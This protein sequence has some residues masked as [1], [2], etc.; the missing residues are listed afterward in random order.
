MG[1]LTSLDIESEVN[2]EVNLNGFKKECRRMGV[3]DVELEETNI[4]VSC[5]V[6]TE[7]VFEQRQLS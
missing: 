3:M 2:D 6:K 7:R 1:D 4:G 5:I